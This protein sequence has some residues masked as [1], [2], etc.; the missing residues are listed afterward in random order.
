M[1]ENSKK[2]FENSYENNFFSNR[3]NVDL[4]TG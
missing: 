1:N 2:F 3:A 4:N